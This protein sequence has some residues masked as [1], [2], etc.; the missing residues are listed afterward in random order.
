MKILVIDDDDISLKMFKNAL[1]LNGYKCKPC[2]SSTEG[3][4]EFENS[5]YDV[6]FTDYTLPD[7]NG[8]ELIKR[9]RKFDSRAYI[10]LFSGNFENDL[11]NRAFSSGANE[12]IEKPI[13]WKKVNDLL[14]NIKEN[15]QVVA[16]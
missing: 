4:F 6:I 12:Y 9:I 10:V 14:C 3:I 7:I 15:F 2:R 1:E 16:V 13:S 8:I 5:A 11:V